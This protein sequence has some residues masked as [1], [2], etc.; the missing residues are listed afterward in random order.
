MWGDFKESPQKKKTLWDKKPTTS[1]RNQ[2]WLSHDQF[3]RLFIIMSLCFSEQSQRILVCHRC[4][5][6][7]DLCKLGSR[8]TWHP[9]TSRNNTVDERNPAHQLRLVV[10]SY[11]LQGFDTS[12]IVQNFFHPQYVF[13]NLQYCAIMAIGAHLRRC[14]DQ[15]V[16][17]HRPRNNSHHHTRIMSFL[18]ASPYK[19]S[20]STVTSWGVDPR[21]YVFGA[22]LEWPLK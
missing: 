11:H 13:S 22:I 1:G 2:P 12:Q 10:F 8:T 14:I 6:H 20:L 19:P 17:F 9:L 15:I 16:G 7:R 5:S 3:G 18:V 4:V 21:K